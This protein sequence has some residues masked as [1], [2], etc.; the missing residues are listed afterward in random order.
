MATW[1]PDSP[2]SRWWAY[3]VTS[4]L[5]VTVAVVALGAAVPESQAGGLRLAGGIA[6]T[7]Q[8]GAFGLLAL[9][10]SDGFL[11]AWLTGM[12]LRLAA[13]GLG[14]A[15]VLTGHDAGAYGLLLGLVGLLFLL[16]LLEAMFLRTLTR[17]T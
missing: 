2:L 14:I 13:V 15:L 6:W 7:T 8:L 17:A 1:T 4:L 3:G 5:L 10:A 16:S 9:A 11:V 12:I